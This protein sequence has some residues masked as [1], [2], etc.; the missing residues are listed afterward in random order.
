MHDKCLKCTFELMNRY[1]KKLNESINIV[2]EEKIQN[3]NSHEFFSCHN[4]KKI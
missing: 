2:L 4:E 3:T 1:V